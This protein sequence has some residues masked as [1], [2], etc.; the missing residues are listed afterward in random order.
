MDPCKA[1]YRIP[2][3]V[4]KTVPFIHSPTLSNKNFAVSRVRIEALGFRALIFGITI[5][6]IIRITV[7]TFICT[8]S[9]FCY[10]YYSIILPGQST[11]CS[12]DGNLGCRV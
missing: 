8:C 6:I 3:V 7:I 1:P 5:P 4:P 10:Y 11:V 2:I 9:Y 12:I